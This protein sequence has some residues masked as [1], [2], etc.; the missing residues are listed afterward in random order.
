MKKTSGPPGTFGLPPLYLILFTLGLGSIQAHNLDDVPFPQN[1]YP[2]PNNYVEVQDLYSV[3]RLGSG[4]GGYTYPL[5]VTDRL[6]PLIRGLA[7]WSGFQSILAGTAE[8]RPPAF[9]IC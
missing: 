1:P 7:L 2:R 9:L 5:N 3:F 8:G 6:D 4:A